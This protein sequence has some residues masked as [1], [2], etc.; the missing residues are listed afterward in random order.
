MN[1]KTHDLSGS[2]HSLIHDSHVVHSPGE[3]AEDKMDMG[4]PL[5]SIVIPSSDLHEV[6]REAVD[7]LR[8]KKQ[9]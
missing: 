7:G 6:E 9:E 5:H 2:S 3:A 1:H 4:R 8:V